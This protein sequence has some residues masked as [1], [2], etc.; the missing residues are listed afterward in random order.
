MTERLIYSSTSIINESVN[1]F[2]QEDDGF[3]DEPDYE[4]NAY[5][6]KNRGYNKEFF[7][8]NPKLVIGGVKA[9]DNTITTKK[10]SS[11]SRKEMIEKRIEM[12][13]SQSILASKIGITT[14][15]LKQ[16]ELGMIKPS[17]KELKEIN[18]ELNLKLYFV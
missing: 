14:D 3:D 10:F 1:D 6:S 18:K 5:T 4:M 17:H 7:K 9:K 11:E 8:D 13:Y 2:Y 12:N 15:K 16:I